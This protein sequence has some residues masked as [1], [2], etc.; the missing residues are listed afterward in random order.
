MENTSKKD[1]KKAFHEALAEGRK[2]D[3]LQLLK[4]NHVF[5]KRSETEYANFGRET[6]EITGPHILQQWG[7]SEFKV[8]NHL[9]AFDMVDLGDDNVAIAMLYEDRDWRSTQGYSGGIGWYWKGEVAV[10]NLDKGVSDTN[11]T[12]TICVR[13]PDN[14]N[15]DIYQY[16]DEKDILHIE[17][18][19]ATV[20]LGG[21]A[22]ASVLTDGLDLNNKKL[23]TEEFI[24]ELK[25]DKL[26]YKKIQMLIQAGADP[27]ACIVRGRGAARWETTPLRIFMNEEHHFNGFYHK[28]N[29]DD[30][31]CRL[32]NTCSPISK[33][34]LETIELLLK[35]G[36]DVNSP[37]HNGKW[38]N[39]TPLMCALET[40]NFDLIKM[41]VK[42]GANVEVRSPCISN[43]FSGYSSE[44]SMAYYAKTQHC[45]KQVVQFIEEEMKR[46][47]KAKEEQTKQERKGLNARLEQ[48][49][50][51]MKPSSLRRSAKRTEVA[52]FRARFP[53]KTAGK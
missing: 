2:G 35:N 33:D 8:K 4:E 25:K 27:N 51:Q 31:R 52:K 41:L 29:F 30:W 10:L 46:S 26:D 7:T 1:W 53:D 9:I 40:N 47:K 36:A 42:Y 6:P 11:T 34:A 18:G 13:D 28:Y 37:E 48:I 39:R 14:G 5:D 49:N 45:S 23:V 20:S 43:W 17:D 16:I 50:K 12:E 19:R 24:K 38:Y 15:K 32:S 22:S 44:E 21:Y 3:A